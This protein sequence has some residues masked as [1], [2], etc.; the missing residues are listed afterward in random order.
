MTVVIWVNVLIFVTV[1]IRHQRGRNWYWWCRSLP[2]RMYRLRPTDAECTF[3]QT[4]PSAVHDDD[5]AI[6]VTVSGRGNDRFLD[7][8]V[9]EERFRCGNGRSDIEGCQ[10]E[11]VPLRPPEKKAAQGGD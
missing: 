2:A 5:I 6:A 11:L 7:A 1:P 4:T 10:L 3:V 8:L 9:T